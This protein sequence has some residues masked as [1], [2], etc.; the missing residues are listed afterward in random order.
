MLIKQSLPK[1]F[2]TSS[3]IKVEVKK[4]LKQITDCYPMKFACL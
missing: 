4:N 2:W 3:G 1:T